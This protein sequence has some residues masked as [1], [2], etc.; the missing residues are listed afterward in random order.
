MERYKKPF[1]ENELNEFSDFMSQNA[2]GN[3][4]IRSETPTSDTIKANTFEYYDGYLYIK[5]SNG[6][7][8]KFAVTAV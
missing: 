3:P 4:V 2:L 6:S 7:L 1:K 8:Y 5:L